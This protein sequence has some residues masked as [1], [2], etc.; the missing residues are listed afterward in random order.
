MHPPRP[1]LALTLGITGHRALDVDSRER[2]A[3]ALDALFVRVK[4]KVAEI[5]RTHADIFGE[6]AP[7]LNLVSALAEG[8]DQI[9]AEA[10]LDHGF[11]LHALLPFDREAYARDFAGAALERFDALLARAGSVWALPSSRA[12][13]SRGYVLA[14]EATIAQCDVLIAAWDGGEARG[15]GGTAEIVEAAVRR[16]V[17]VI[18]LPTGMDAEPALLWA[19][20]DEVAPEMLH[21]EDAPRRPLD[22]PALE[23]V[24]D[25]LIAPPDQAPELRLFLEEREQYVRSRFEWTLFLAS[26]GVQG[27]KR[28]SFRA[29]RYADAARP[30][31]QAYHDGTADLCGPIAHVA[32]LEAASAWAGGLAQHYANVFRSGVVLNFA[33]AAL[34]VL[35]ALIA[36]LLPNQ[37]ALLLVIELLI[38]G[39]VILNTAHGTRRQ[40]HRRWLDYRF[41]AEELRPLRSL[42]MLGAANAAHAR[43][44]TGR[45]TDWYAQAIWRGLGLPPTLV[46]PGALPRL[47]QHIAAH[48]LDGQIRYHR[49]AAHRM[50]VLDHRLHKIGLALLSATILIGVGTLAGLIFLHEETKHA[51]PLLGMLSAALP[52]LG[53]AIFGIRG[54]GDFAGTAGRSSVTAGRLSHLAERLRRPDI[55]HAA[56]VRASEEAAAIMLADLAEWRTNYSHRK[57]AI[58]S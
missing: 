9:A 15:P 3:S 38:I 54:A 20:F 13:G 34:A 42:K 40:W 45:W 19:G 41:L 32:T 27:I 8:A 5:G 48:E 51:A 33:G 55:D 47:A 12:I 26:V 10:A 18:H 39:A 37:K 1:Q 44:R 4:V 17:P 28:S 14:G 2:L 11:V 30:D 50:H 52:T 23:A 49:S 46:G 35:M 22:G 43:D 21:T 29:A 6:G 25:G 57:L 16:G 53:A 24:L 58:P 36:G 56:A 7:I 31:W